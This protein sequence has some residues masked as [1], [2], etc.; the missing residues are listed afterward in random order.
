MV[1]PMKPLYILIRDGI[2]EVGT[3]DASLDNV[4]EVVLLDYDIQGVLP[5][6]LVETPEG[7]ALRARMDI[8]QWPT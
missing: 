4:S 2:I 7:P 5:E 8:T 3:E 1:D 6:D